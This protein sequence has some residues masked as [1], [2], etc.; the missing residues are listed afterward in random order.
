MFRLFV[1]G[2]GCALADDEST[3]RVRCIE[4]QPV[5]PESGQQ[6]YGLF[7]EGVHGAAVHGEQRR[8][9]L[10]GL[11]N[12]RAAAPR[13]GR[14]FPYHR[15]ENLMKLVKPFQFAAPEQPATV[16]EKF[17]QIVL[18][19]FVRK[20]FAGLFFNVPHQ[21][22]DD[23]RVEREGCDGR[24]ELIQILSR[25]QPEIPKDTVQ[26][27]FERVFPEAVGVH[28]GAAV[29]RIQK[30]PFQRINEMVFG[31][32]R[33]ITVRADMVRYSQLEDL[34]ASP[35]IRAR[36][37]ANFTV[38]EKPDKIL[39]LSIVFQQYAPGGFA[40]WAAG[41]FDDNNLL[42]QVAWQV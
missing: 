20:A 22:L 4:K 16:K 11:G 42:R 26:R 27:V 40:G 13:I 9:L 31:I 17:R 19:K 35:A 34:L 41:I 6:R 14:I 28:R 25:I 37:R 10:P 32:Q 7:I 2:I 36:H 15:A 18:D 38:M 23:A 30:A 5:R 29:G 3:C 39:Q 1:A 33:Y 21:L 24:G 8:M 12:R